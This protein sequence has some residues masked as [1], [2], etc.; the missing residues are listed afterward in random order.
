MAD[1]PAE[2]PDG[3]Y[4]EPGASDLQVPSGSG[5]MP[6]GEKPRRTPH[7]PVYEDDSDGQ[8]A[9]AGMGPPGQGGDEHGGRRRLGSPS[10]ADRMR[11]RRSMANRRQGRGHGRSRGDINNSEENAEEPAP[12]RADDKERSQ[13][14]DGGGEEDKGSSLYNPTDAALPANVRIAKQLAKAF[15]SKKGRRGMTAGGV[16]GLVFFLFSLAHGPLEIIHIGMLLQKAHFS[17]QEGVGDLTMSRLYRFIRSGGDVG[18]TRIGWYE[19]RVKNKMLADL[20]KIGLEP[21]FTSASS[22]YESFKVDTTDSK[23]PYYNM[24][25]DELRTELSKKGYDFDGT[26]EVSKGK[27]SV[28]LGNDFTRRKSLTLLVKETGRKGLFASLKARPLKK[29]GWVDWHPIHPLDRKVNDSIDKLYKNWKQ[30]RAEKRAGRGKPATIDSTN[31]KEQTVDA[32]G[33]TVDNPIADGSVQTV[34]DTSKSAQLIQDLKTSSGLKITGGVAAAAGVACAVKEI[35]DNYSLIQYLDFIKPVIQIGMDAVTI[36]NQAMSGVGG[37]DLLQA[38]FV[39]RDFLQKDKDTG[40]VVSSWDEAKTFRAG[41][42]KKGGK[43]LDKRTKEEFSKGAPWWINWTGK[44][45][46]KGVLKPLCSTAGT[47]ATGAIS[48]G[49]DVITGHSV[50]T[51]A[52]LVGSYFAGPVII[53]KISHLLVGDALDLDNVAGATWGNLANYGTRFAANGMALLDGGVKLTHLDEIAL[54]NER[55]QDEQQ[56]FNN[57]SFAYRM[58]NPYDTRSLASAVIDDTPAL[59]MNNLSSVFQSFP[60]L[61]SSAFKFPSGLL[62]GT[63]SAQRFTAPPYD[64]PFPSIGFSIEDRDNSKVIDP[65]ENDH[66]V[67]KILDNNGEGGNP[68]YIERAKECF[69]VDIKKESAGGWNATPGENDDEFFSKLYTDEYPDGC[70]DKSL[71]WIR[72]RSFILQVQTMKAYACWADDEEACAELG[73]NDSSVT[74]G[75]S[76]GVLPSGSA[77]ALAGQLIGFI[78]SGKISCNG[79]ASDCPDIKNTANG[80]SIKGGACNVDALDAKLLGMMLELAQMGHTFVFSALCTDHPSNPA[81]YHHLGKAADFNYIDGVFM[82][83][84]DSAWTGEKLSV[85]KKLDQDVASFMPKSTGFGQEGGRCHPHFNFLDGFDTF[86]DACHHQHIQVE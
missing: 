53:D 3:V 5:Y 55:L 52:N 6:R 23:S 79:Q 54:N 31:A 50:S 60:S 16:V 75:G 83:P 27:Y 12:T 51:L 35:N 57:R 8:V 44:D 61:F 11:Q 29:Y 69:N 9:Q 18:E 24:T 48:V 85:G 42:G 33:N 15:M 22:I 19:S 25:E 30:K 17:N 38:G 21:E 65:I 67:A 71:E 34:D 43:D 70:T 36:A 63:V 82:G 7:E 37:I 13:V 80:T 73:Y 2:K 46:A 74:G 62:S 47:I 66:K 86:D 77:Q 68:D 40:K 58:F 32:D 39:A 59:S 26:S 41:E 64:Y 45:P 72:V 28:K 10:W 49:I 1:D 14:G 20:K 4:D 56:E 81:S 78:N 84:S 76:P